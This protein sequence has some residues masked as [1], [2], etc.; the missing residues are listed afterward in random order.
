MKIIIPLLT[1]LLASPSFGQDSLAEL[2]YDA[3]I[4]QVMLQHPTAHRA[5]II[6]ESGDAN[7]L[8]S[9]G[10]FDPKLFGNINQ[11]YFKNTQYYSNA[12]G[13]VK[14]P[15]W[16]GVSAEAGYTINEGVYLNPENR[17]PDAGLWYAGLRL[18]LGRGLI[19]DQRRAEFEKAKVFQQG[20]VLEQRMLL[21]ELKRDASLAYWKWNQYYLKVKVYQDA[22][23]NAQVRFEGIKSSAQFGDRPYIDTL[24]AFITVQNRSISLSQVQLGYQN[25]EL[26]LEVYLWEQGFIPIELEGMVPAEV[27]TSLDNSLLSP[28]DSMIANHPYVQLNRLKLEQ[29]RIDLKWK[30][31]QLKPELTLKYNAISEPIGNNPI[32]EYSIS[33]YQWGAS[34]AYPILTRKERGNVRL[35][36]LKMQDQ[37][38]QIALTQVDVD[39]KVNSA[40]NNYLQSIE[41][42]SVFEQL[43][44]NSQRLYEAEIQ[45]FELGESSVF[46]INSRENNL[47]KTKIDLIQTQNQ[48][49]RLKSELEYA[50]LIVI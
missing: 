21:N 22:V 24:E 41:Q 18:D 50:L 42:R 27:K 34:F 39:Y 37:E 8:S 47:L 4:E 12:Q 36:E 28:L 32:A 17:V 23:N 33:N 5:S 29:N 3:F 19:M 7:L 13:G 14:V 1:L 2:T 31:E 20:T 11:K 48:V 49:L 26:Q 16:F 10:Q 25:A 40:L 35:A 45:L 44:Q 15:T 38:L 46:L 6:K 43:V 9:R 30:K